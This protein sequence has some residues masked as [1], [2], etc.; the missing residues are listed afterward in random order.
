M[1]TE[2]VQKRSKVEVDQMLKNLEK[3]LSQ[4]EKDLLEMS[5][6]LEEG[7]DLR[8]PHFKTPIFRFIWLKLTEPLRRDGDLDAK[9]IGG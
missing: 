1:I 4:C 5:L 7:A 8:N 2:N 9:G 6:I 3:V